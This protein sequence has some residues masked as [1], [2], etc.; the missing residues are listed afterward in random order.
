MSDD[1]DFRAMTG[2][3]RRIAMI[4][5]YFKTRA[6]VED[7]IMADGYDM[8]EHFESMALSVDPRATR[9]PEDVNNLRRQ[10]IMDNPIEVPLDRLFAVGLGYA[11]QDIENSLFHFQT[12]YSYIGNN[13]DLAYRY[14]VKGIDAR[15]LGAFN[16]ENPVTGLK[17]NPKFSIGWWFRRV[18]YNRF[19]IHP[20]GNVSFLGPPNFLKE[21]LVRISSGVYLVNTAS[22]LGR[23]GVL[24]EVERLG[25]GII[26]D[27][28]PVNSIYLVGGFIYPQFIK[29]GFVSMGL[30]C[31]TI[32]ASIHIDNIST[33]LGYG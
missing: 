18:P 27:S 30:M 28:Q 32:L 8:D 24:K 15:Y 19:K 21:D 13:L 4:R 11:F 6:R 29:G 16:M 23:N 10:K 14:S 17:F 7:S 20:D 1:I 25:S 31:K 5:R 33:P 3:D 12:S 2:P 9:V 26:R 22:R